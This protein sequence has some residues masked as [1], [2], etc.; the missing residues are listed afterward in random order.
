MG[1]TIR[2]QQEGNIEY[3]PFVGKVWFGMIYNNITY[4]QTYCNKQSNTF[5]NM[6]YT[7]NEKGWD[8]DKRSYVQTLTF[9]YCG[10]FRIIKK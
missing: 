4:L 5:L 2:I 1:N 9:P 6:R 10:I 7:T 3:L 8:C